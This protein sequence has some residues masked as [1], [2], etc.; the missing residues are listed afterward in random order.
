MCEGSRVP[1]VLA[2]F[3]F[4]NEGV[5]AAVSVVTSTKLTQTKGFSFYIFFYDCFVL[6]ARKKIKRIRRRRGGGAAVP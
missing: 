1:H 2:V 6:Q 5:K 4:K 3:L